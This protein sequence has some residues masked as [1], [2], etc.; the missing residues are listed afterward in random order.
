MAER[1]VQFED[2]P[3]NDPNLGKTFVIVIDELHRVRAAID[4]VESTI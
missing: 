1:Y 3:L 2:L 4:S